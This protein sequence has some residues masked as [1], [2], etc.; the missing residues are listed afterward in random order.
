MLITDI[1]ARNADLYG[2]EIALI[3][4]E[5][6]KNRKKAITWREFDSLANKIA[7]S[8]MERGV[9]K[10]DKVIQLMMNCLEWLPIYFG[11]LRTGAWAVPL[12]FRFTAE[13]IR[14]CAKIVDAKALIFGEEFVDP[15]GAIHSDLETI[16]DYVF[17]GPDQDLPGYATAF[18]DFCQGA[19]DDHPRVSLALSDEAGLYFTSGTTGTPKPILLTHNNLEFAALIENAHHGQ[20]HEDNFLCIP[21]LYH[22]GA[23]MHWFGNLIV[24]ARAVILKGVKPQWILEAVSEEKVTIVWLL[25][26]WAQDI[27]VALEKGDLKLE[28]YQLDQWRLM[29]IGAQ[30]VPR[31]LVRNW[32]KIFPN[33]D[34]D[35][36][37]GLTETTGPG[38]VHLGLDNIHKVGAIGIPGVDWE[39]RI[40]DNQHKEVPAGQTGELMVKGPGMMKEYYKAPHLTQETIIDGWLLTGDMARVDGEGFIWLVDRKKDVI[41]CGGENIFPVQ[42][43]DFLMDNPKIQDVAVI[44]TP[45]VRLGE[46]ATA[47]IQVKDSLPMTG[48]EVLR[49]CEGLPRY[50]RP[51]KVFFDNI[52]RNATGK[53][54]KPDLRKKYAGIEESFQ[55]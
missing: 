20:V 28:D 5:P 54:M 18:S 4:R 21:P 52:P 16:A 25:V 2:D 44:G 3:E 30:P 41:I 34:Y 11:I 53:I 29:H 8:L 43:E 49:F 40:V 33:H 27:L 37:Y 42:I 51:R 10:G 14:Y 31:S 35:T 1:L 55:I 9:L 6:A 46:V 45:D 24:G 38:C 36:N 13:E 12:N 32:K 23:K 50:R 7:N 48:E 22:T 26:P 15:I 47:I 19:S 17:L 39:C